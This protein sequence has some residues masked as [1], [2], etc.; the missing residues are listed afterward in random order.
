MLVICI[1][2]LYMHVYAS[3]QSHESVQDQHVE[4]VK[5]W[6]SFLLRDFSLTPYVSFHSTKLTTYQ[7]NSMQ[8]LKI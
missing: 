3:Q 4:Q 1:S 2:L 6:V 5:T 8:H 7:A